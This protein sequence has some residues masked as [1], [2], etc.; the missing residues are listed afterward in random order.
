MDMQKQLTK[1]RKVEDRRTQGHAKSSCKMMSSSWMSGLHWFMGYH[2]PNRTGKLYIER[3]VSQAVWTN[4]ND[5]SKWHTFVPAPQRSCPLWCYK[6][7]HLDMMKQPTTPCPK[8]MLQLNTSNHLFSVGHLQGNIPRCL[9]FVTCQQQANL[10]VYCLLKEQTLR[11]LFKFTCEWNWLKTKLLLVVLLHQCSINKQP[12]LKEENP[13]TSHFT[14]RSKI[15]PWFLQSEWFKWTWVFHNHCFLNNLGQ[16]PRNY[17]RHQFNHFSW[18]IQLSHLLCIFPFKKG[19]S[20]RKVGKEIRDLRAITLRHRGPKELLCLFF[21]G[22]R[23][24][25]LL[26]LS[27][28]C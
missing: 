26:V 24:Y 9:Q 6:P 14:H 21:W 23:L 16:V 7:V 20:V 25:L 2:P 1:K 5:A 19:A 11:T 12:T 28:S 3:W 10:R 22:R 27:R 13:N 4:S 18:S 17:R 8:W 15:T